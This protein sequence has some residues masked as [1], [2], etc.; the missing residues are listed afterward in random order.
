MISNPGTLDPNWRKRK[1]AVLEHARHTL[2]D[3]TASP[4]DR[5]LA[6]CKVGLIREGFM[7]AWLARR[8][9]RFIAPVDSGDNGEHR[10]YLAYTLEDHVRLFD[11]LADAT[12]S[13]EAWQARLD[14]ARLKKQRSA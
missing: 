6:R 11:G 14:R 2:S 5:E 7:R 9:S 10:P 4:L 1:L 13:A 12:A 8:L 3:P